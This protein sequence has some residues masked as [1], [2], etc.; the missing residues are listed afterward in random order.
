MA[1]ASG[2]TT[3]HTPHRWV[4]VVVEAFVLLGAVSGAGQLWTG[5]YAPPV[6]D[7]EALGLDS[8][9]LPA[10]WLLVSVAVP[11]GVALL[12][13]LR[14]WPRTPEIVLAASA[15]LLLEVVV[16]IPFVGP[17]MLQLVMGLIAVV[18]GVLAWHAR[19][20]GAWQQV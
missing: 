6:S 7:L 15:L 11:S 1:L 18:V 9:K 13:A 5:T 19:T 3:A 4:F 2:I 8:W 12:A 14:R 20:T 17:S 16:Q 10:V